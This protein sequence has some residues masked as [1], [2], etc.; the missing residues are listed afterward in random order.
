MRM[1][2]RWLAGAALGVALLTGALASVTATPEATPAYP[3]T[4]DPANFVETVDNPYFPLTPGTTWVYEGL[5]EGEQERNE[6]TVTDETKVI[7]GVTCVVVR[8]IVL[9]DGEV[10]EDTLDWYAQDV[11]GNVWYF[12]EAVQDFEDGEL[13]STAGSWEAG[14]DGAQPGIIMLAEPAVGDSYQQELYEGEAEDKGKVVATGETVTVPYGTFEDVLVT[15]DINPFEPGKV[16]QKFYAPG[17]GLILA[18]YVQGGDERIELIEVR[19]E[20]PLATPAS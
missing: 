17:I 7:L 6:V 16:E 5:S 12:G 11:D 15:E 4:I 20:I 3:V 2:I 1:W 14:V 13:V 8:D 10:V 9:I 18:E 19:T